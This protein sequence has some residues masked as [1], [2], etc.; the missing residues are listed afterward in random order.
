MTGG[1]DTTVIANGCSTQAP[2]AD[3]SELPGPDRSVTGRLLPMAPCPTCGY[4]V[5]PTAHDHAAVVADA[6]RRYRDLFA[7]VAH[8]RAADPP[9][10]SSW[11]PVAH[12]WHVVD[13][14]RLGA[15]RLWA[16]VL[17]PDVA[18]A[19]WDADELAAARRYGALGLHGGLHA[20]DHAARAWTDAHRACPSTARAH[21]PEIG[22]MTRDVFAGYNAHEVVHHAHD[23]EARLHPR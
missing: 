23:V 13:V 9:S 14:V 7:G 8:A 19:P 22:T 16:L 11:S 15:D 4:D 1:N 18:I 6:H 10:D 3:L 21:H 12:L 20:L 5:A 17:D 2:S